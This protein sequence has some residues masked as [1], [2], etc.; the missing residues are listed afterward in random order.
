MT[1]FNA[2]RRFIVTG[3]SSGIGEEV[4]LALNVLGASV[5][6]IARNRKRLENM[7]EKA[8]NPELILIRERDLSA[9]IDD[10]S[11]FVKS[12]KDECGKLAGMA[13]CAGV[14]SLAPLRIYDRKEAQKVFDVNYFAPIQMA[15]AVLDKRNNIGEQTSI[16]FIASIAA[17]ICDKSQL[18]YAG[19]KAALIASARSIAKEA[20]AL[21]MRVN[22]IS[23]AD[24]D[25]PM[26]AKLDGMREDRKKAY[27]FGFGKASD[28]A[29]L[30]VFL[31]S[32][33]ASWITGQDYVLDGGLIG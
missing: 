22:T 26:T 14:S 23:P 33:K 7:R 13:Y 4:A 1:T 20:A 25:T 21:K 17:R 15:K 16:V 24:I 11:D 6:A 32:D 18:I 28:V 9:N 3:A 30:A 27:P 8:K 5:I 2:E 29:N 19:S 10:L 31:L 12:L